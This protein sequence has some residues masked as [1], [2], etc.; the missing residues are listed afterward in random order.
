MVKWSQKNCFRIYWN[1][2]DFFK[3]F[4]VHCDVSEKGLGTAL[5]QELD[6][7]MKFISYVSR[8]L[9]PK[10]ESYHLHSGKLE[11]LG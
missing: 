3:P 1:P 4:I 8:T 10:E 5:Y 7:I 9:T 6:R 11:L 2:P